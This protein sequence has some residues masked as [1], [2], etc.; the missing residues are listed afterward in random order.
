MREMTK[1]NLINAFAGESQAH[2]RYYIFADQAEKEGKPNV[3]RL[4]RAIAYSEQVHATNH[5]K[6]LGELGDTVENLGKGIAGENFE[7]VE[8]Y[9]AY[10]VV[11]DH[12]G[13]KDAYRVFNW[14]REAEE[15]HEQMFVEAQNA[16]KAG[17][18]LEIE[19]VHICSLC[20]FTTW[21]DIPERCPIC[22]AGPAKFRTF[23]R[24]SQ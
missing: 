23:A 15:V 24:G 11:A 22:G 21:D 5:F 3:A 2:M 10:G 6:V 4:F 13:E 7:T 9:P 14:A 12:Q 1:A 8:M 17:R 16:V 20:G 18:D 19:D